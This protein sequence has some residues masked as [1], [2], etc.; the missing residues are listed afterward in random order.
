MSVWPKKSGKVWCLWLQELSSLTFSI[1][2]V[3]NSC[4]QTN[5]KESFFSSSDIC[6]PK[7][8]KPPGQ[9]AERHVSDLIRNKRTIKV[10]LKQ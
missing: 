7:T 6:E 8:A 3:I 9:V 4:C 2:H 10:K 5:T 1:I